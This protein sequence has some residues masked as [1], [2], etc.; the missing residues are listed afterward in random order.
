MW[1]IFIFKFLTSLVFLIDDLT[2]L[3]FCMYEFHMT[4]WETGVLFFCTA[5]CLLTYGLTITGFI[6]DKI[7]VKFSIFI[8]F[9]LY[10]IAKFF[11][12]FIDNKAQL[13][14]IMLTI[15]PFAIS[16]VYPVL[17]LG[18]KRLTK[19][20][21]RPLA[22]SIFFGSMILGAVFGGP[23]VDW[24]RHDYKHSSITYTHSNSETGRDQEREQEFSAYRVVQLFGF[25][26]YLVMLCFLC[27]Y[28]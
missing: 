14:F 26:T 16:L 24:I 28:D 23:I 25:I 18:V 27:F 13:Y 22:F 3:L 21:A 8:G 9:T 20:N 1:L 7:G 19:E 12:I 10:A 15:L 11:L 2:F 4:V 17:L 5:I 6:I